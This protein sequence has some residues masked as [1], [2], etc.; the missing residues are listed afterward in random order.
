M[1]E[2]TS[3][4]IAALSGASWVNLKLSGSTGAKLSDSISNLATVL[5]SMEL[6]DS[7]LTADLIRLPYW[8][9]T[10]LEEWQLSKTPASAPPCLCV[11]KHVPCSDPAHCA[12]EFRQ[13][14][15]IV[16][17][18]SPSQFRTRWFGVIV[19]YQWTMIS[20]FNLFIYFS[21]TAC[22]HI[23]HVAVALGKSQLKSVKETLQGNCP[24]SE[25]NTHFMRELTY[26]HEHA[27]AE[28]ICPHLKFSN[29]CLNSVHQLL[30]VQSYLLK[31]ITAVQ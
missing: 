18:M 20:F 26:S 12:L 21:K 14:T 27:Y 10:K 16:N 7:S 11:V 9:W 6:I 29:K 31:C 8:G 13:K 5:C 22:R 2:S 28:I 17:G 15:S 24:H 1:F 3:V 25:A 4:I 19:K 30:R 23:S